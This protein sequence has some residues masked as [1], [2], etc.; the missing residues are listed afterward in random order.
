[1]ISSLA[2][3]LDIGLVNIVGKV[4]V[5]TIDTSGSTK[6]IEI[7][8]ESGR[9]HFIQ[10]HGSKDITRLR[11]HVCGPT[12]IFLALSPR[13]RRLRKWSPSPSPL[14]GV[15]P[16]TDGFNWANCP[17]KGEAQFHSVG[18]KR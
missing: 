11:V 8:A 18:P 13:K 1:L 2:E 6:N 14:P 5:Q 4:W 10:F 17:T 16:A 9:E 7:L 12:T 3:V 15:L